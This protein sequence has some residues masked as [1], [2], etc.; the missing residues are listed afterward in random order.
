MLFPSSMTSLN[1]L[2]YG[3]MNNFIHSSW[4]FRRLLS[5]PVLIFLA[6]FLIDL[7]RAHSVLFALD[8]PRSWFFQTGFVLA[9][10]VGPAFILWG[11]SRTHF[12]SLA[13]HSFPGF[14]LT[15]GFEWE[16]MRNVFNQFSSGTL[17]LQFASCEDLSLYRSQNELS[18]W[19]PWSA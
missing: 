15:S 17:A 13:A 3:F 12:G 1:M 5:H 16:L 14:A 19:D 9:R 10:F 2:N 6:W 7:G 18:D 4:E 11:G 8:H